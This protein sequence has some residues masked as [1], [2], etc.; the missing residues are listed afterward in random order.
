MKKIHLVATITA[1]AMLA[2]GVGYAAWS[3]ALPMSVGGTLGNFEVV[4]D[5]AA[6]NGVA[7][8]GA[9]VADDRK[10]V[11]LCASGLYPDSARQA[12]Y[13]VTFRNKGT[14]PVKLASYSIYGIR[15]P[16]EVLTA[17][18]VEPSGGDDNEVAINLAADN[19]VD[20]PSQ[21]VISVNGTLSIRVFVTMPGSV[22]NEYN[23]SD[24]DRRDFAFTIRANFVQ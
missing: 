1:I 4:V 2:M 14:M 3:Q 11:T 16:V 20:S 24:P 19:T 5:D 6:G 10:A 21:S 22:G 8:A 12:V 23:F 9:S 15:G 13:T 18:I 7:G 17:G